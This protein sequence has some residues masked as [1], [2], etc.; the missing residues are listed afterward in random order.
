MYSHL[1]TTGPRC[2]VPKKFCFVVFYVVDQPRKNPGGWKS[3][4]LVLKTPRGVTHL[5]LSH[6]WVCRT[7]LWACKPMTFLKS[8]YLLIAK[9]NGQFSQV[10][11]V[12]NDSNLFFF[13]FF[14]FF[15]FQL[16]FTV[17]FFNLP[18]NVRFWRCCPI[19]ELSNECYYHR[20]PASGGTGAPIPV[21]NQNRLNTTLVAQLRRHAWH[22]THDTTCMWHDML[23]CRGK[24]YTVYTTRTTFTG[25]WMPLTS[26]QGY[27]QPSPQEQFKCSLHLTTAK[28]RKAA[29]TRVNTRLVL[30]SIA[31]RAL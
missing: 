25:G 7:W 19:K 4:F 1:C 18:T 5:T 31:P 28:V 8:L 9:V 24:S 26:S 14:L 20:V 12:K 6:W 29:F 23:V 21:S 17:T 2:L 30:R 10:V 15:V 27:M 11:W 13:Y 22:G 3:V 16:Q